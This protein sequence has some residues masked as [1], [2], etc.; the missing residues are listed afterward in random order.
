[1][2]AERPPAASFSN[3]FVLFELTS[4]DL[5]SRKIIWTIHHYQVAPVALVFGW[6]HWIVVRGYDASAA[7]STYSDT[8][9][10]INGFYVEQPR[11]HPRR[12]R[13]HPRRTP[14]PTPAAAAG[15]EASPTSTSRMR[16]ERS[17]PT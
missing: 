17:R 11:G 4:E 15:P 7:P 3:H 8:S 1:M 6:D 10:S 12:R 14:T 13:R 9:Y 16:R 5:I 2:D